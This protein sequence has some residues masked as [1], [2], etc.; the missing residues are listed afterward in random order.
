MLMP[1]GV[2]TW[3]STNIRPYS[4]G[5][6]FGAAPRYIFEGPRIY[7]P[8][9]TTDTVRERDGGEE[10]E[11]ANKIKMPDSTNNTFTFPTWRALR[12]SADFR[13]GHN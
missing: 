4:V 8:I 2:N 6:I 12:E 5:D 1:T 7:R 13:Q 11:I 9:K 3:V 10:E